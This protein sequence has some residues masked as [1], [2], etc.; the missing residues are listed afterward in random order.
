[1]SDGITEAEDP[2]GEFF[3]DDRLDSASL[4]GELPGVL[5]RMMDFCAGHPAN[6]D[7]TIVQVVFS[8][9]AGGDADGVA[10]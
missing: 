8:A 7:C 5:Q 2:H 6:D 10:A 3:G 1:M 9:V 4:C